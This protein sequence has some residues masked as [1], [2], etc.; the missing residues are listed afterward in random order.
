MFSPALGIFNHCFVLFFFSGVSLFFLPPVFCLW[1]CSLVW[2]HFYPWMMLGRLCVLFIIT[3]FMG[4]FLNYFLG[5]FAPHSF[6][7]SVFFSF[8]PTFCCVSWEDFLNFILKHTC[9][10]FTSACIA[11]FLSGNCSVDF[12]FYI[13]L[14]LFYMC[15]LLISWGC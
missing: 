12:L 9:W 3:S 10:D 4:I 7:S 6:F 11:Y 5:D 14:L 8:S 15:Y 1:G 2:I 13:L